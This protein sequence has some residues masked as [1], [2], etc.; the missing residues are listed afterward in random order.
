MFDGYGVE[1][2][3][4]GEPKYLGYFAAGDRKGLG[5][6]YEKSGRVWHK[7]HW[8]DG[9]R[10]LCNDDDVSESGSESEAS[11]GGASESDA[12]EGEAVAGVGA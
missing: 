12:L 2:F 7:G 4:S 1:F 11:E 9:E 8:K 6:A 5:T 3:K 10:F